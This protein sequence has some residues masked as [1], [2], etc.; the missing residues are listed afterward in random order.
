MKKTKK[1]TPLRSIRAYCREVCASGQPK[2]VRLCTSEECPL[3]FFRMGNN[4]LRAGVGPGRIIKNHSILRGNHDSPQVRET[5][6]SA[7]RDAILK[8]D[9]MLKHQERTSPKNDPRIKEIQGLASRI[10]DLSKDTAGDSPG[11]N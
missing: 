10:L 4:P 5:E 9:F 8:D 11:E 7:K 6:G 3:H 1:R 2:E